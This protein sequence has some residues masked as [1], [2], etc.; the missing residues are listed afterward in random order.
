MILHTCE[1]TNLTLE[2]QIEE[3]NQTLKELQYNQ[4]EELIL[5]Q[6]NHTTNMKKL[7][8]LQEYNKIADMTNQVFERRL[9]GIEQPLKQLS[10]TLGA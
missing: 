6:K 4:T 1:S 9:S 10:K 5:L 7:D 2:K 8:K 3:M